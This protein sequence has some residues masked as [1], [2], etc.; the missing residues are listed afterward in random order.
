MCIWVPCTV[1]TASSL[2]RVFES[3]HIRTYTHC[4]ERPQSSAV[5]LNH[6]VFILWVLDAVLNRASTYIHQDWSASVW[7]CTFCYSFICTMTSIHIRMHTNIAHLC[8]QLYVLSHLYSK[9]CKSVCTNKCTVCTCVHSRLH[10][11]AC[12]HPCNFI[13]IRTYIRNLDIVIFSCPPAIPYNEFWL[14]NIFPLV[15][16][17]LHIRTYVCVKLCSI[18]CHIAVNKNSIIHHPL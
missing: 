7:R 8:A 6:F 17:C 4:V 11:H 16:V 2:D 13:L 5:L 14:S 1:G 12:T 10:P 9:L 3:V 15:V 18:A